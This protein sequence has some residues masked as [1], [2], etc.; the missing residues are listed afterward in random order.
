MCPLCSL[1]FCCAGV[2]SADRLKA[3]LKALQWC[4]KLVDMLQD[5]AACSLFSDRRL[6]QRRQCTE[7]SLITQLLL[8]RC[9]TSPQARRKPGS[10]VLRAVSSGCRAPESQCFCITYLPCR[11]CPLIGDESFTLQLLRSGTSPQ[12]RQ[13]LEAGC[14]ELF[15]PAAEHLRANVSGLHICH[16][17]TFL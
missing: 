8:C 1:S 14:C 16:A 5:R 3:K 6:L 12:A 9:G 11:H 2:V 15:P 17:D 10:Q 13:R 7:G 4:C